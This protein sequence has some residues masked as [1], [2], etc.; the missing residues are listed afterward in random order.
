[1][2]HDMHDTVVVTHAGAA[3]SRASDTVNSRLAGFASMLAV[4]VGLA[5]LLSGWGLA[6]PFGLTIGGL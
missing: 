5:I 6:L 1:M 3:S 2:C 4:V